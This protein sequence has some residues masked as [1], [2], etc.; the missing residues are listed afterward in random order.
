MKQINKL[1]WDSDFFEKRIGSVSLD[2]EMQFDPIGF[3]NEAEHNFD[4]VYVFS[5]QKMLS[6]ETVLTANLDLVDIMITMSMPFDKNLH[7]QKKYD[8][9]NGLTQ[10]E[11]I[12][13]YKIAEQTAVVSRFYI[14]E[15]IGPE[16]TKLLYRKWI[17][18]GFNKLFSDGLFLVEELNSIIGI[19]LIKVDEENNVGYFTLTGVNPDYKR[20]GIGRKLWDQAFGFFSNETDI[21]I[22]KSPFSFRNTESFNF[23]LKM[24]FNKVEE[25]KYI[26]HFR[27]KKNDTL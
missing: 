4:L 26:Y 25:I 11:I 21:M 23:H 5:Y 24:G 20:L 14:E 6:L 12:E 1:D 8:F 3:I 7:K 17:D 9:K 2:N 27:N 16:K 13:C 15:V 10:E 22:I 19:H 18:N